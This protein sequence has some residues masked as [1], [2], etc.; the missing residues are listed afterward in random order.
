MIP[1]PLSTLVFTTTD[2]MA[3]E[4]KKYHSTLV[5]LLSTKKEYSRQS[6]IRPPE[7][8]AVVLEELR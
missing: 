4:C 8:C 1:L 7:V 3:D 5:E 2:G 6:L